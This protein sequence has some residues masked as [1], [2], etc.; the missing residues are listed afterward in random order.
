MQNGLYDRIEGFLAYV[1]TKEFNY[2]SLLEIQKRFQTSF[3][4]SPKRML[5]IIRQEGVLTTLRRSF[6][7]LSSTS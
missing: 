7:L 1:K 2:E 5:R 6:R 3:N 4:L